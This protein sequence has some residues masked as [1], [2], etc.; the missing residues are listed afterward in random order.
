MQSAKKALTIGGV[1]LD[2]I[3][4]Y[5]QMETMQLHKRNA[6]YSYLLLEEGAKIEVTEQNSF[7]G[8]GAG[9]AAASLRRQGYE[10][11]LF[12]KIG[13]DI[14]GQTVLAE[15]Q[16][17]GIDT[18]CVKKS[19]TH[20][21]ASSFVVP[22]LD[23]D[24]TV[25]AY[26]GATTTL[27]EQ[28]I[29]RETIASSDF[30]YVTSLSKDS[31]ARLPEI[32]SHANAHNTRVAINPGTSQ[33]VRGSGF[34]KSSLQGIDILILNLEEAKLLMS[35][36]VSEDDQ[37]KSMMNDN[38]GN[39]HG[40]SLL[41]AAM[42]Y[43]DISFSLRH[44]FREVI[45]LGARIVVVTDGSEGVYVATADNLFFHPATPADVVNTLG[46]GDAFGSA[47]VGAVYAGKVIEQAIRHGLVNSASVIGYS[48]AKTGLMDWQA[49]TDC[50]NALEKTQ[51][52]TLAW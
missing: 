3:I 40:E 30:V 4:S 25:F 23:G 43:Q 21:T 10:A 32:V 52:R 18:G 2:T 44:F 14:P 13:D 27:L 11:G 49:L 16:A 6:L 1:T 47:F 12:A 35:S 38:A 45:A 22:S 48:D 9:N 20:G 19:S 42:E 41:D 17:Q 33:L 15:L 37:L 34:L 39:M 36:L 31:A 28:D 7:T 24:R 46:A 5:E 8:G 26:R 51:L 29:P 50:S